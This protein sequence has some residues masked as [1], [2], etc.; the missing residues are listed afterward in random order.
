[1]ADQ[2]LRVDIIGDAR[3]LNRALDTAS[4]RLQSFGKKLTAVG[5]NLSARVTLPLGIAG[6]AAIKMAAD[7]DKSMT[8]I[9]TLVGV[10]S[11]EVDQM[12]VSAIQMAKVAGVSAREAADALFFITSAGFRGSEALDILD[13]S[14]KASSIGLGETKIVADLAT[15]AINAYGI[16]NLSA[17]QATDVL[18]GAVREGKLSAD[19]L[20]QSMGSVLP[21]SSQLGVR[22]SEVGATFAAMSRTGTD[23]AM[24]ATQIRGVLFALLK[25]TKQAKDTLTEFGL[26]A[27]GLRQ[28]IKDEGLLSTLKTLTQTFG[29]NEEA[30]G[31]VFANTRALS[32]VLDL[33]G[34][35][36]SSTEQIFGRMNNTAGI[37]AEAFGVLE[38]SA[39]FRLNKSLKNL[40]NSFTEIGSILLSAFV[41]VMENIARVITKLDPE[42]VKL[43]LAFA[44]L[45]AAIPLVV[46]AIG[47]LVTTVGALLSPVY[48]I[49]ASLA[50]LLFNFNEIRNVVNDFV[51]DLKVGLLNTLIRVQAG[52]DKFMVRI[53]T[54]TALMSAFLKDGFD[55][56]FDSIFE[57][58][59]KK[60]DEISKKTGEEIKSNLDASKI[61]KQYNNLPPTLEVIKSLINDIGQGANFGLTT[62]VSQSTEADFSGFGIQDGAFKDPLEPL[63]TSTSWA[64]INQNVQN[65]DKNFQD[66]EENRFQ[67]LMEKSHAVGNAVAGAFSTLAD[68]LVSSLGLAESGMGGF[69]STMASTVIDLIAMFLSQSIA[70]AIAAGSIS[71]AFTGAGAIF[72]APAFIATAVGGVLAAFAAIPKFANGGIVSAP[73]LGLM[74]EYTGARSNPEVIAPLDKLK[75]MLGQQGGQNINVGGEFRIQGQDL[76]VALQRAE[77]NRSRLL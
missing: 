53:E 39:S 70:A 49:V 18:T 9:K 21:V 76:V 50:L 10:A 48:L 11:D 3:K 66:L 62:S 73:T 7:F 40:Q 28:Q 44:G 24:A 47:T 41:P 26:S 71:A 58:Q 52:F 45:A 42:I 29:D 34:N 4:G 56:N 67:S 64:T 30:Q 15:S 75:G 74:G 6:A 23:A 12:G 72:T 38:K 1:M 54:A 63:A 33:M 27:A 65:M 51:V 20:A 77:K 2:K 60:I 59:A 22:F 16:E 55:A 5:K 35:N 43:G 32:G 17:S 57:T 19:T 31:R 14:L 13:Q 36:L 8:Q 61:L 69:L 68:K 25:P 46:M 37:T